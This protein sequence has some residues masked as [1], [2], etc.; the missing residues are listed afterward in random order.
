MRKMI[1]LL[2]LATVFA[3]VGYGGGFAGE[4]AATGCGTFSPQVVIDGQVTDGSPNPARIK[5]VTVTLLSSDAYAVCQSVG[6]NAYGNYTLAAVSAPNYYYIRVSSPG[7]ITNE[8]LVYV[9][10][11][12]YPHVFTYNMALTPTP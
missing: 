2:V 5:D 9:Y 7:F 8:Q 12:G 11:P 10:D 1:L 6:G 4:I 3:G